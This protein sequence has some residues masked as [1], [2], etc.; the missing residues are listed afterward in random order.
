MICYSMVWILILWKIEGPLFTLYFQCISHV[1]LIFPR[2]P[3]F[4][5]GPWVLLDPWAPCLPCISNVFPAFT[6]FSCGPVGLIRPTSPL[7]TLYFQCIYYVYLVFPCLPYFPA[8]TS[9][10]QCISN[11]FPMYFSGQPHSD[12]PHLQSILYCTVEYCT[13]Y[14]SVLYVYSGGVVV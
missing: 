3:Y 5:A 13:M 4:P 2:L 10:F 9:Y 11:V 6:L 7:F 12:Q 14:C 1:Y 8:F